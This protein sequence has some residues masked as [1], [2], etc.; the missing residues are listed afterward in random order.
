MWLWLHLWSTVFDL[1]MSLL[2][3]YEKQQPLRIIFF[4][5]KVAV[6]FFNLCNTVGKK[7]SDFTW[8]SKSSVILYRKTKTFIQSLNVFHVLDI[9]GCHLDL[10]VSS[11]FAHRPSPQL[12]FWFNQTLQ[13]TDSRSAKETCNQCSFNLPPPPPPPQ[14]GLHTCTSGSEGIANAPLVYLEQTSYVFFGFRLRFRAVAWG[15]VGNGVKAIKE[16]YK[17]M[18]S[19]LMSSPLWE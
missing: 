4:Y 16:R 5:I 15:W 12:P 17:Q 11:Y 13:S 18:C 2:S 7:K 10:S 8:Q 3:K 6:T 19:T 1:I 9:C 14:F